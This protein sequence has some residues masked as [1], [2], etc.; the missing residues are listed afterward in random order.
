MTGAQDAANECRRITGDDDI[1]GRYCYRSG[2]GEAEHRQQLASPI[3]I[4]LR[5]T[6]YEPG[7]HPNSFVP[8]TAEIKQLVDTFMYMLKG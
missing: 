1:P 2:Y 8:A 3:I 7:L 6:R 5:Y 4:K